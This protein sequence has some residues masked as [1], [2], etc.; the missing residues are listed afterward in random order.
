MGGPASAGPAPAE[1][2]HWAIKNGQKQ[3]E[4][5]GDKTPRSACKETDLA[6]GETE[7]IPPPKRLRA[8]N[9]RG[10]ERRNSHSAACAHGAQR[11]SGGDP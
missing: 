9:A 4:E 5:G 1:N 8:P 2:G 7:E 6:D 10:R 11:G 3:R